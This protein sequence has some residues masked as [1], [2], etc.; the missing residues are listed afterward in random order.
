MKLF[1]ITLS[2]FFALT[3]FSV[4]AQ[5][6]LGIA[7]PQAPEDVSPLLIGEKVP[8]LSLVDAQGKAFDLRQSLTTKPTILVFYRGGWCPYCTKQLSG[9]QEIKGTLDTLGYQLIAVSTDKPE[10]L[11]KS[12][13]T[14]QLGY[15]LLSDADGKFAAAMGIAFKAPP[16][17]QKFLPQTTDG[18][19]KDLILPV[20]A[21]F[22]VNRQSEIRFEYIEPNFKER[23]DPKLLLVVAKQLYS[24]L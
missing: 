11:T 6:E 20:P 14:Q 12:V 1:S 15:T 17:Y 5:H 22:V 21:V 24:S 19:D 4:C 2:L 23:V 16:A 13:A 7:Y 8:S 10:L 9:L 3:T 18:F